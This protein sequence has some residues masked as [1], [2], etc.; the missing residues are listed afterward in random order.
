MGGW[1]GWNAWLAA[2][3]VVPLGFLGLGEWRFA[4]FDVGVDVALVVGPLFP[5]RDTPVA[6]SSGFAAWAAA[7]A[8][9][10]GH[11]TPE[12]DLGARL[13]AVAS[14]LHGDA[15][16]FAPAID[17]TAAHIALS[18]YLRYWFNRAASPSP[19][20]AF[21]ELRMNFNFIEPFGPVFVSND[22]VWSLALA[23]GTSW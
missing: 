1:G 20:P 9:L 3:G 5:W 10:T 7:G 21:A 4:N 23:A 2:R 18:P 13:Q 22:N 15:T 17:A 12:L 8:W 6:P 16:V 11:L 14:V 19:A